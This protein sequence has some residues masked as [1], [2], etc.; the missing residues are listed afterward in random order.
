MKK[1]GI[2]HS[3]FENHGVTRVVLNNARGLTESYSG[4]EIRLIGESFGD[5][6]DYIKTQKVLME[7]VPS[8]VIVRRLEDATRDCD[9]VVVENPLVGMYPNLTM[10]L[11][12]YSEKTNKPVV[13]RHHDFVDDRPGLQEAFLEVFGNFDEAYARTRNVQH[14]TLTSHDQRR[15]A[16]RKISAGVLPNSVILDD[17]G[18]DPVKAESL[19]K[20]FQYEGIISPGEKAVVAPVRIVGRKN[21]EEALLITELLGLSGE[22]Y[23]LIAT[24][25]GGEKERDYQNGVMALAEK[26]KIPC[27]LGQ[28]GRHIRMDGK[29]YSVSDLFSMASLALTTGVR[30]GFGLSFLESNLSDTLLMGRDL[31][32]V[33]GDFIN[34]GMRLGHLY[35]EE[36]LPAGEDIPIRMK[37]IDS[38]LGDKSRLDELAKKLDLQSR[39]KNARENVSHNAEIIRNNYN[40]IDIAKRLHD[41]LEGARVC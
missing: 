4:I 20:L 18:Y 33:T 9:R 24:L 12:R 13:W 31:P 16:G 29:G 8:E 21:I 39:I 3:D 22:K 19:R 27:S 41:I 38:I 5:I 26:Y 1:I 28:A 35:G 32:D 37:R 34:S 40:H 2:I 36:D 30:E 7:G 23:R 14:L 11:K 17:F 10:A 15:L 25:D 6:P